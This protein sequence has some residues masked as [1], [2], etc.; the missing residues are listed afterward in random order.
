MIM[1]KNWNGQNNFEKE[2]F[3]DLHCLISK[4]N[5]R[6]TVIKIA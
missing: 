5:Y 2:Q 6:A 3:E 1:E 4:L